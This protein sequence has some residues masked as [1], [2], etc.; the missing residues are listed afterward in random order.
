M[1]IESRHFIMFIWI[2]L[3]IY[4]YLGITW[5]LTNRHLVSYHSWDTFP[6]NGFH[7]GSHFVP[8][9]WLMFG[10]IFPFYAIDASQDKPSQRSD[11]SLGIPRPWVTQLWAAAPAAT[12]NKG[13]VGSNILPTKHHL[14][15]H[16]NR[17]I[18]SMGNFP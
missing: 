3:N 4:V 18:S 12:E 5:L 13:P 6:I 8:A 9:E 11:W 2:S 1:Y 16:R 17:G 15:N 10:M 7:H 14:E